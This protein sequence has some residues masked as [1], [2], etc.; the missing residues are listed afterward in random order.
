MV[1]APIRVVHRHRT[2]L[3][4]CASPF[5]D[6]GE[7]HKLPDHLRLHV[8]AACFRLPGATCLST[9]ALTCKHRPWLIPNRNPR[10]L[11]VLALLASSATHTAS[12]LSYFPLSTTRATHCTAGSSAACRAKRVSTMVRSGRHTSRPSE[13]LHAPCHDDHIYDSFQSE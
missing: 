13:L 10:T 4:T 2:Q 1:S 11:L 12:D 9:N 5:S 6:E 3:I 8:A 7:P